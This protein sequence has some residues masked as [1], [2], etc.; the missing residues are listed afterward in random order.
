[1]SSNNEQWLTDGNC[2]ECRRQKYCTSPC[3]PKRLENKRN[4][5]YRNYF[6]GITNSA[7]DSMRG[8]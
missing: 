1:M 5:V 6:S 2:N 3:K 4:G 7:K 8:Q